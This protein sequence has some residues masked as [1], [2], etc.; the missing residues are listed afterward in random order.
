MGRFRT[1][2]ALAL[3]LALVSSSY[4]GK[5]NGKGKG[6]KHGYRGTVEKVETDNVVVKVQKGKKSDGTTYEQTFRLDSDTKYE[7][8]TTK[9]HAK[10]EKPEKETSPA[11]LSDL[12]PGEKVRIAAGEGSAV[13]KV[14]IVKHASAAR[15]RRPDPSACAWK[16]RFDDDGQPEARGT[17]R[18]RRPVCPGRQRPWCRA[19]GR[20]RGGL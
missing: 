9:R 8:V 4:A 18:R 1:L 6:G 14:S 15:N 2:I 5:G 17:S 16:T 11:T 20:S 10:G 19:S 3:V 7:F 12:K 13:Q